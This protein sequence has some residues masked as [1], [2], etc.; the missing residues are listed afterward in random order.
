MTDI[1]TGIGIAGGGAAGYMIGGK[2]GSR[3]RVQDAASTAG[4]L[5]ASKFERLPVLPRFVAADQART[6]A[7]DL[8][9]THAPNANPLMRNFVL[10]G[11]VPQLGAKL[12]DPNAV[13]GFI[14]S[15]AE[16]LAGKGVEGVAKLHPG[17]GAVAANIVDDAAHL[18]SVLSDFTIHSANGAIGAGVARRL[19]R[20]GAIVAGVTGGA[21]VG[22]TLIKPHLGAASSPII[23]GKDLVLDL[24]TESK[25]EK[26]AERSK[27]VAKVAAEQKLAKAVPTMSR[28]DF[29]AMV[30]DRW[31]DDH[32]SYKSEVLK[33]IAASKL[34]NEQIYVLGNRIESMIGDD[35]YM[36]DALVAVLAPKVNYD[37]VIDV[38][39]G[40]AG[41]DEESQRLDLIV[42]QANPGG[43]KKAAARSDKFTASELNKLTK[44]ADNATNDDDWMTYTVRIAVESK[45]AN[46]AI[47]IEDAVSAIQHA[48]NA[49]S[50]DGTMTEMLKTL[51]NNMQGSTQATTFSRSELTSLVSAIDRR[52]ATQD[53]GETL[54]LLKKAKEKDPS[55][56]VDEALRIQRAAAGNHDQLKDLLDAPR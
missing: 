17:A 49:T 27:Q 28:G 41:L 40:A 14:G 33:E 55:L 22:A 7:R 29:A 19:V 3:Q 37:H 43:A 15:R 30:I 35:E 42:E 2:L 23:W 13:V 21:I 24:A 10:D 48:D 39:S 26:A 36:R 56:T 50:S 53:E 52:W 6:I 47:S 4:S 31:F 45:A 9:D 11:M 38:L 1:S 51:Y 16:M 32:S 54:D 12:H 5:Y 8:L 18:T 20:G 44:T 46:S 34:T 25:K